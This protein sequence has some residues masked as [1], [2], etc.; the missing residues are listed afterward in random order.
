MKKKGNKILRFSA[1]QILKLI[2]DNEVTNSKEF[3]KFQEYKKSI[4]DYDKKRNEPNPKI[5]ML[6]EEFKMEMEANLREKRL[7]QF[8]LHKPLVTG[9]ELLRMCH[10]IFESLY[11]V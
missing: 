10:A 2:N 1:D 11:N 7:L 6:A 3:K 9:P 8:L 4:K 5:D